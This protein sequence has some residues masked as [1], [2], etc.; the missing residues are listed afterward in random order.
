MI[1]ALGLMAFMAAGAQANWKVE[2]KELTANEEVKVSTHK[3]FN[4]LLSNGIE[5]R[6]ASIQGE[7]LLLAGKSSEATGK[8]A[9]GSCHT[10]L[11]G[12]AES[13]C[14]P[15]NQ[16]IKAAGKA[17]LILSSSK[18]YVLFSPEAGKPF[19]TIE[20][21]VFCAL[22]ETDEVTGNLVAE[23]GLLSAGVFVGEDCAN[24]QVSHL[25]QQAPAASF[26]KDVLKFGDLSATLDGIAAAELGG[27]H[28][29][30]S[31][32]GTV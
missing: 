14:D 20:F 21:S 10:F 16:P 28:A 29:G 12:T 30:K 2:A 18:N 15:I 23:C 26:P 17:N 3:E 13:A 8:V 22:L 9:F 31:W 5:I 24:H 27:T 25:L 11:K 6:C 32:S 1:A 4:L 7:D 19:T